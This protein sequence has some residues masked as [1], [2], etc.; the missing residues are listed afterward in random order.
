[1]NKIEINKYELDYVLEREKRGFLKWLKE[2]IE[3]NPK[4]VFH[5][6]DFNKLAGREF[7]IVFDLDKKESE[8]QLFKW[9]LE[10]LLINSSELYPEDILKKLPRNVNREEK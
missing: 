7:C 2:E 6:K 5:N 8:D 1:M 9:L 10:E 3:I 4:Y